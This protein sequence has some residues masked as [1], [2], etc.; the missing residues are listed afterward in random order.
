MS[1]LLST[2]R[3]LA[4]VVVEVEVGDGGEVS[5]NR[6]YLCFSR[7]IVR[8]VYRCAGGKEREQVTH[9]VPMPLVSESNPPR[10]METLTEDACREGAEDTVVNRWMDEVGSA[11]RHKCKLW[12]VQ[13]SRL[14]R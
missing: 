1:D 12:L 3:V 9:L 5:V 6:M 4:V 10:S 2:G 8:N 7:T 11:G 14:T 13:R